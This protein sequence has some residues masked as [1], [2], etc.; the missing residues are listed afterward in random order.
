D[1]AIAGVARELAELALAGA[2]ALPGFFAAE[3][4]D[5]AADF[6]ARYTRLSRSPAD[7]V[8]DAR[9]SAAAMAVTGA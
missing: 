7:D 4:I 9:P 8:L 5:E 1:P 3:D 2:A 6:F